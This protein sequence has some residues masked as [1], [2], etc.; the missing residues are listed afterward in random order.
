MRKARF[1][2][3]LLLAL[4]L[5]LVFVDQGYP[6]GRTWFGRDLEWRYNNA[7]FH[8]GPLG[9]NVRF[10][11]RN[12]GYDTNVYFG[13][14]ENQVKDYTF[15]AGPAIDAYIPLRKRI[16]FHIYESP[17]YVYYKETA[18]ERTWNNFFTGDVHFIFN[19]FVLSAGVESSRAKERWNSEITIPIYRKLNAVR[20][21]AFVQL[22]TR[23]SFEVSYRMA[24]YN[25]GETEL[26]DLGYGTQ[27]NR[28]EHY[29]DITAYREF[30]SRTRFFLDAEYGY[31]EFKDRSTMKNS[32]SYST[33]AGLEFEPFGK[34]KGTVK[35]GYKYF[36]SVW[37]QRKDFKGIVGDSRVSYR[38]TRLLTV[39]GSYSRD[40]QYSI[41]YDST[42]FLES[43][44]G[45]GASVYLFRNIRLDYDYNRGKSDYPEEFHIEKR[46]DIFNIHT[47]AIYVRLRETTALGLVATRRI[48]NSTLD[49]ADDNRA[50][51]GL[52]L[53][54][55]F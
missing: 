28:D 3:P 33:H 9:A 17:Q 51:I 46:L 7:A 25:Y 37:P 16:V 27:L 38:M 5:G 43:A 40:V 1:L 47:V 18:R 32:Q 10:V 8:L 12:V 55:D 52:N 31:A 24:R 42:F 26:S 44:Y 53:T 19:R 15:T 41:W 6:W 21:A 49:W 13:A 48:R 54:Y 50:L 34:V 30:S 11:L 4:S 22:A 20:G 2:P 23:T 29:L 14:T 45:L 39:R 36:N 35:I